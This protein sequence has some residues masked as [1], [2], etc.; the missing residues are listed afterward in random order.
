MF[1][2]GQFKGKVKVQSST[3]YDLDPLSSISLTI[4]LINQPLSDVAA[5][6]SLS[7]PV[8]ALVFY[9]I[10]MLKTNCFNPVTYGEGHDCF[11]F[12]KHLSSL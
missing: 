2:Q 4:I 6:R 9:P 7:L 11:C 12:R 3:L 1:Y 8:I 10:F 5:D